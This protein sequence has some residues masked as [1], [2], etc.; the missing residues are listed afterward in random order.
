MKLSRVHL[1]LLFT[2]VIFATLPIAVKVAL[3]E[4]S[5]PSLALLR[6][7]GAALL[8]VALQATLVRERV[9]TRGDYLR[10]ALYAVLGVV[11]N[12]LLYI[13]A[14]TLTTATAAQM[15]QTAGPAI[16]LLAAILLGKEG[17]SRGKWAGIALA[18]AGALYLVG[19]DLTGGSGVGNLLA[20]LNVV[21]YSAYLVVSR[22]LVRR[23]H[24]LTVITWVFVF[25][26]AGIAPWGLP[27]LLAERGAVSAGTWAAL[28]WIV[29]LPTVLAYYLNVWAL[30]RV[31][32]SV[33]SVYVYLQPVG[34]ALLAGPV[35]GERLSPRLIPAA[36]LI[37]AGV[38]LTAWTGRVA[39]RRRARAEAQA[40]GAS[41]ELR[42]RASR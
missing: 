24:P 36:A 20:L 7:T 11:A 8:F 3:R 2:Q 17:S 18:G 4:L 9:R 21:C 22:D 6:V 16:T 32:S 12:Q 28:A 15:L 30:K 34:T 37:F 25:G 5:S 26:V 19:L 1:V 23:Y 38:A 40:P 31:E 35:L 39:K 41:T 29:V 13:T 42:S 27:G 10:L 33:V 14:L